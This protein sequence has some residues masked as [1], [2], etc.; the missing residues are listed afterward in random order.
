MNSAVRVIVRNLSICMWQKERFRCPNFLFFATLYRV[1]QNMSPLLQG[2]G[3]LP[4]SHLATLFAL[5]HVNKLLAIHPVRNSAFSNYKGWKFSKVWAL[6]I[7][8]MSDF[9]I[10][11][12]VR[13][14]IMWAIHCWIAHIRTRRLER[15]NTAC[16]LTWQLRWHGKDERKKNKRMYYLTLHEIDLCNK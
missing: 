16:W 1:T 10:F 8:L 2:P 4:K 13:G 6:C 14:G 12:T 11:C 5:I 15:A 3:V 9:G 7:H